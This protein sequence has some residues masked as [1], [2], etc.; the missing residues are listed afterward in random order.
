MAG[1]YS[2]SWSYREHAILAVCRKLSEL[3]PATPREEQR[4]MIRAA[5]S[6]LKK[7]L[8]DKVASVSLV[9]LPAGPTRLC[10]PSGFLGASTRQSRSS[11][12]PA[13]IRKHFHVVSNC[14]GFL[15]PVSFPL[16][17]S[18]TR[19]EPL[20]VRVKSTRGKEREYQ[21]KRHLL[22]V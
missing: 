1:A 19:K 4:N 16:F 17:Y 14:I 11:I 3:P 22:Q 9:R 6:L 21:A 18:R 7:A 8:L 13:S 20:Q 12:S 2:K 5:V 15:E 10:A